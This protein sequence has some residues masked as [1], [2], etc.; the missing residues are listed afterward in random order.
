MRDHPQSFS[1]STK[2]HRSVEWPS[3]LRFFSQFS[4]ESFERGSVVP[5]LRM[6]SLTIVQPRGKFTHSSS[7]IIRRIRESA[8]LVISLPPDLQRDARDSYDIAVKNV[9]AMAACSTLIGYIVRFGVSSLI[10]FV[11]SAG[12]PTPCTELQIPDKPLDGSDPVASHAQNASPAA[13]GDVVP[14]PVE[15]PRS[16]R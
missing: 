12:R 6:C 16:N 8:K 4:I 15:N 14:S 10:F 2:I 13:A 11:S 9:F 5:V 1:C 3:H 7:K